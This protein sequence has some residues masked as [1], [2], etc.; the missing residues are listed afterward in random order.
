MARRRRDRRS[1]KLH[2]NYTID[3]AARA[4]TVARGTVRRW[5]KDG[6]PV[7]TDQRPHLIL[8]PDLIDYLGTRA[9]AK[10]SCRPHECY[11]F[12]CRRPKGPAFG[13]IEFF[14]ITSTSGNLLALCETCATVMHKRLS[15]TKLDALRAVVDVTIRQ[16]DKH[17]ADS[18]NPC[19]ND[20]L[21][22]EEKPLA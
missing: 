22:H 10:Q 12:S 7:L 13:C 2:R 3:Q 15:T 14:P 1:I 8:G 11:C 5:I 4:L 21:R 6:L 20:Q 16:A 9:P 18:A 19:L 17:I